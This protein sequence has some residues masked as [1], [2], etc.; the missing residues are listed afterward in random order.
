MNLW[1]Q[2]KGHLNEQQLRLLVDKDCVDG[3]AITKQTLPFCESCVQ[4]KLARKP[5]PKSKIGKSKSANSSIDF[6]LHLKRSS[7]HRG[8]DETAVQQPCRKSGRERRPPVRY[9]I[10]EFIPSTS[11]VVHTA[12]LASG[13]VKPKNLTEPMARSFFCVALGTR[14]D[15]AQAV[16]AV[17]KF[18]VNP[19]NAHLTAV[20]RIFRQLRNHCNSG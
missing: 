2:R 18:N 16:R 7:T 3:M 11:K 19:S 10:D 13:I 12:C 5:F 4:G 9:G 6:D 20:N 15:I 8:T 17:T 14:P 1:H